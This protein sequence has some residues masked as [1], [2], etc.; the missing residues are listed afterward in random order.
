MSFLGS[1]SI[2]APAA[3]PAPPK[4]DDPAVQAAA[5]KERKLAR[6]RRGRRS[7]ILSRGNQQDTGT[8]E[9]LGQ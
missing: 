9:L 8:K 7:T 2:P 3:L 1:P 4:I 6:L 5:A